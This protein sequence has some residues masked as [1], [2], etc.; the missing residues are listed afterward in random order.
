MLERPHKTIKDRYHAT[1]PRPWSAIWIRAAA[2]LSALTLAGCISAEPPP[3]P[4]LFLLP[5]AP[6]TP[7]PTQTPIYIVIEP[8]AAPTVEVLPTEPEEVTPVGTVEAAYAS[9]AVEGENGCQYHMVF[10][11]DVTIPDDTAI[12]PGA[13]F[14]KTWRLRNAGTCPWKETFSMH[15]TEG[16]QMDSPETVDLPP[17]SPGEEV[18]LSVP[19]VAPSEPG[20]YTSF[21]R[22]FTA[23]DQPFGMPPYVRIRVPGPTPEPVV[24]TA[25]AIPPTPTPG[26]VPGNIAS[27]VYNLTST[28]R[29]IYLTGQAQG[30]RPDVF[31]MVGD[32]ITH[33]WHF[34]TPIGEGLTQLH[35]YGYL[36]PVIDYFSVANARIDNSFANPS[37]AMHYGWTS[38]DVLN[39]ANGEP[40]CDGRSP[41]VCELEVVRPSVAIIMIG[42]NDSTAGTPIA[43][44]QQNLDQIVQTTINYGVIPILSTIPYNTY[45]DIDPFNRAV[46][47]VAIAHDIPWME[48]HILMDDAPNRGLSEDG[49]HPSVP[50]DNNPA[51]FSAE[52]LQYGYTLR[53]LLA[54]QALY[55][56]WNGV[57]Y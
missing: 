32:S 12:E 39:P 46:L 6:P 11:S 57:M 33:A 25:T 51:N 15:W 56:V 30:N 22:L 5:T 13:H 52:N 7:V 53:N 29:Q 35:D 26:P 48:Y 34:M 18:D 23:D 45:A 10:V 16:S 37:L 50:P 40:G 54:V 28:A 44:Y 38:Y 36:G 19:L 49:M 27:Y 1:Q 47:T 2:L 17:A 3:T 4:T 20:A 21:W 42:S 9:L 8:T 43:A 41:L 14:T 55:A 24:N 31:S